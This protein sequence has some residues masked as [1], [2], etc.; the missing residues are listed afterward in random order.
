[1]RKL[2]MFIFCL[3]SLGT[4]VLLTITI[5]DLFALLGLG[6]FDCILS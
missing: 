5:S 3:L 4:M 1:M 6:T 2:I